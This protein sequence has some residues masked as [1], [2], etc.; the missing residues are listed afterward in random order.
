MIDPD[1]PESKVRMDKYVTLFDPCVR[2]SNTTIGF[3]IV[4]DDP[5]VNPHVQNIIPVPVVPDE[6]FNVRRDKYVTLSL[7]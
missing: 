4:I 5:T 2:D 3:G 7:N 6:E 1:V